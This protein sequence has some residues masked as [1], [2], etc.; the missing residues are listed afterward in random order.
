[1]EGS[2]TEKEWAE[3]L[4]DFL[5]TKI[6]SKAETKKCE[7]LLG[8]RLIYA[9][10]IIRYHADDKFIDNS[11]KYETDIFICEH[12][13]GFQIPRVVIETKINSVTTH[14]AITY[15]QKASTHKFVH[16]YLRYGILIGKFGKNGLP[17]RLFRHGAHFDFMLKT[18]NYKLTTIEEKTLCDVVCSEIKASK[19]LEKLFFNSRKADRVHYACLHRPLMLK[20]LE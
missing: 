18:T 4:A 16:P 19:K 7:V 2:M 9:N 14:D 17:G 10:E 11:M 1:M 12:K 15:S 20:T 3:T 6:K 8:H 13:E 5:K